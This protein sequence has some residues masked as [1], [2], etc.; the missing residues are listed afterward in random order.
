MPGTQLFANH[1]RV[2]DYVDVY[3]KTWVETNTIRH[4]KLTFNPVST[5]VDYGHEDEVFLTRK[6]LNSC[7]L[8]REIPVFVPWKSRTDPGTFKL[9]SE[10]LW[11][12][13]TAKLIVWKCCGRQIPRIKNYFGLKREIWLQHNYLPA[14]NSTQTR[15]LTCLE[16][17][18]L[19][20]AKYG[21]TRVSTFF[22]SVD[23]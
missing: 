8:I 23:H 4:H 12:F 10:C 6:K 20:I 5:S 18:G 17:Q 1:F 2:G 13:Q 19:R 7:S 9:Q 16:K 21:R 3:A 15:L 14:F 11:E 22:L